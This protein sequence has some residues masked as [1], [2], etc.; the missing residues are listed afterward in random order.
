MSYKKNLKSLYILTKI[1]PDR[2]KN[3]D[4]TYLLYKYGP[5]TQN[6]N[7]FF[8]SWMKN[9]LKC[10]SWTIY[11]D[12][13]DSCPPNRY[14]SFYGRYDDLLLTISR[15]YP[16]PNIIWHSGAW[17]MQWH[18]PLGISLTCDI[19][20]EKDLI[21]K[22][23]IFKLPNHERYPYNICNM[24]CMHT[25]DVHSSGPWSWCVLLKR[26]V[27][28]KLVMYPDFEFRKSFGTS[29]F[30]FSFKIY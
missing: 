5:D 19:L 13:G 26:T 27:F 9:S 23:D 16:L 6:F 1:C 14:R 8:T 10:E 21:S 15:S 18:R 11:Q 25:E 7:V 12:A 17:P 24:C 4:Y 2:H 29:I 22:F 20:T 28:P 30:Y 3:L